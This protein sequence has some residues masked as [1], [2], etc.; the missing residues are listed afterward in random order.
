[1]S[2]HD[3]INRQEAFCFQFEDTL[4]VLKANISK[5]ETFDKHIK[6]LKV[7]I[8]IFEDKKLRKQQE[9]KEKQ[10][11]ERMDFMRRNYGFGVKQKN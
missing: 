10:S 4:A 7:Q 9:E 5:P 8:A 11:E 3:P 2:R 6:S 1:M